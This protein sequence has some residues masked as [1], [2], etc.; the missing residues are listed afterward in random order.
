MSMEGILGAI[1][2]FFLVF[3]ILFGVWVW[4]GGPNRAS[5]NAGVFIEPLSPEI[6]AQMYGGTPIPRKS[7]AT[8]T[9]IV[10]GLK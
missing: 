10:P 2:F 6:P 1:G 3:A 5:S 7:V 9:I 4:T 8:T